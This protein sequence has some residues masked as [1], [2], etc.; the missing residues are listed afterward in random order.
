MQKLERPDPL[1]YD[2]SCQWSVRQAEPLM[3]AEMAFSDWTIDNLL[4]PSSF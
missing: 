2:V 4:H 3:I 1:F